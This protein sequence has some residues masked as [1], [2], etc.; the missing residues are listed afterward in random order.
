MRQISEKKLLVV[1]GIDEENFFASLLENIDLSGI[2]IFPE[3]GKD[4]IRGGLKALRATA[5]FDKVES[6][7]IIRDANGNPQGA[8]QS[9]RD[10]LAAADLP[11][12]RKVNVPFGANPLV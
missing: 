10:A 12:P 2:Q 3:G 1:E 6:L 8:F 11:S 5:N 9:V 7:A 4:K